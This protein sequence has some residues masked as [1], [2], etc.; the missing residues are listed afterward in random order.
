MDN[1]DF[2]V[3]PVCGEII[4]RG[5]HVHST[6]C[7][8][9]Y[10]KQL[11]DS[12]KEKIVKMYDDGASMVDMSKYLKLPYQWT[13]KILKML[14]RDRRTVKE[15]TSLDGCKT[16]REQTMIK[17]WGTA[18][19]FDRDNPSRK[20]W[21][22]RLLEEEGITNVFQRKSVIEKIKQTMHEKY[23]DD[24]IYYNYV[25]GSTLQYWIEKLGEEEGVKHYN[26]I[27]YNKGKTN[28]LEYYIEKYG[29]EDGH[30][31]FSEL[32]K[33]R[34]TS[35]NYC[36]FNDRCEELLKKNNIK[37]IREFKL[38][39]TDHGRFYSYDFKIGNLLLELN[40]V[41]WHCSPKKYKAND[42]VKFPNGIIIKA[43]DKWDYD[44]QKQQ[45]GREC[46]YDVAV[47][48]EDE[49]SE[50]VLLDTINQYN[51]YE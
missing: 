4:K 38:D 44:E 17:N 3:C 6:K 46:G 11:S 29:E 45:Y 9:K 22:K 34:F 14:G 26:E 40:G 8:E 37:Y 42:L 10:F 19:N 49:F 36:G 1:K 41:Y 31:M 39:R 15:A 25:K 24:E 30:H 28:R 33:K 5:N 2:Y 43:K 50:N 27:C 18:H 48:W 23:T 13:E 32:S 12:K 51:N 7:R 21:E 16:K 35:S 20:A 47:I